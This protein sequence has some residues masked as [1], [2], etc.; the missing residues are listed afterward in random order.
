MEPKENTYNSIPLKAYPNPANS[1][2]RVEF[3]GLDILGANFLTMRDVSG[4]VIKQ[5]TLNNE[6]AFKDISVSEINNGLYFITLTSNET[7]IGNLKIVV[8]K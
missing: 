2:I 5:F 8:L 7:M 4:K 3:S 6:E 1:N